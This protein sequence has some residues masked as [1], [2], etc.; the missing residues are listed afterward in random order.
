[1]PVK[2]KL[3]NSEVAINQEAIVQFESNG[4]PDVRRVDDSVDDTVDDTIIPAPTKH[5][6]ELAR[7]LN[8]PSQ[9]IDMDVEVEPGTLFSSLL[10]ALPEQQIYSEWA[11][12]FSPPQQ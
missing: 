9:F 12:Y 6:N 4:E 11:V 1:M 2:K 7:K 3:P 5:V 8:C 10:Y